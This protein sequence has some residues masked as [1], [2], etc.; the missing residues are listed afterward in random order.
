MEA[1]STAAWMTTSSAMA[2]RVCMGRAIGTHRIITTTA[3]GKATQATGMEAIRIITSTTITKTTTIT[4]SIAN[5]P[6]LSQAFSRPITVEMALGH[7][8]KINP[9]NTTNK[10]KTLRCS[11]N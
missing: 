8:T 6:W 2:R 4:N 9:P 10:A 7:R 1:A 3:T 5:L 11:N